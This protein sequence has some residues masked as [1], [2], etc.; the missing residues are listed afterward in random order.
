MAGKLQAGDQQENARGDARERVF[1]PMKWSLS[2]FLNLIELR[3]QTWCFAGLHSAAGFSIPHGDGFYLYAMLE[4]RARLAGVA[5]KL[6]DLGPG[7]ILIVL[8]GEAHALRSEASAPAPTFEY[9]AEGEYADAP[10]S[11]SFGA[12]SQSA[13]L[14]C[15]NL[16]VRWPGGQQPRSLPPLLRPA[17]RGIVDFAALA[18]MAKGPGSAAVLTRLANLLFVES[19]LQSAEC[20][21]VFRDSS[22]HDPIARALQY[23]ET[24]PF[25]QWTVE[26]LA[27]KVGMG[28]ANFAARFAAQLGRTPFEALTAE[29]MRHAAIFLEETDLKVA[30]IAERVGYRS[31]A[32]FSRRFAMHYGQ[33]PGTLRKQGRSAGKTSPTALLVPVGAG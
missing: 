21:S 6:I 16:K 28:R 14:L 12:G 9:L 32:A 13:R 27:R 8:S 22:L 19:F 20:Q 2:E 18:E 25:A 30:E 29:R 23:I 24:H 15:G 7:D 5:G 3:S 17:A 33:S 11:F 26:G 10:A 31:E 4:G 1:K